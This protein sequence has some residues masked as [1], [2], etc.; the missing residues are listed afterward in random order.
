MS[1]QEK[2]SR[3]NIQNKSRRNSLNINVIDQ[4]NLNWE[5]ERTSDEVSYIRYPK[6]R[7]RVFRS[8]SEFRDTNRS[9]TEAPV[10]SPVTLKTVQCSEIKF[11][12]QPKL[13]EPPI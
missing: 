1:M 12:T 2:Y 10:Q 13:T 11:K 5:S 7:N 8:S 9:G 4:P 6:V 3:I